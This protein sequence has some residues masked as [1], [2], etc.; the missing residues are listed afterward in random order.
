[1]KWKPSTRVAVAT[2][3]VVAGIVPLLARGSRLVAGPTRGRR[4]LD[5]LWLVLPVLLLAA[6][7]AAVAVS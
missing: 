6:L 5:L 1:M 2:A 4:A 3:L 7:I